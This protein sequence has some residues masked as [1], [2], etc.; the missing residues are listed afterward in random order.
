VAF[1]FVMASS[2]VYLR[3]HWLSDVVAGVLLGAGVAL[4]VAGVA[5]EIRDRMLHRGHHAPVASSRGGLRPS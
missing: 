3:A 5:T 4:A 1:A 2:R